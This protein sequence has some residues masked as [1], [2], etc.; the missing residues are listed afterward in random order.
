MKGAE[1]MSPEEFEALTDETKADLVHDEEY[2]AVLFPL[3]DHIDVTKVVQVDYDDRDFV[4]AAPAGVVYG[5][6]PPEAK[7][8]P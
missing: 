1:V 7:A 8:K 2:E 3:G 4:P 5:L 6:V